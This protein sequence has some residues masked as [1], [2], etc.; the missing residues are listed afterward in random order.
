[1]KE[2]ITTQDIIEDLRAIEPMILEYKKKY[3][4][5]SADFYKHYQ[6]GKLEE[7]WDFQ[8]WAGLYEW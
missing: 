5:S 1:M 8:R 7:K 3:K 6:A 4:L 2:K